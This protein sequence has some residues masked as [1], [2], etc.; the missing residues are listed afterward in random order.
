MK[1]L[2]AILALSWLVVTTA[3]AQTKGKGGVQFKQIPVAAALDAARKAKKPLFVEIYSPTCHVCQG[4]VPTFAESRV[5]RYYNEKFVSAK[6]DVASKEVVN[7]LRKK[8]IFVPSLPLFLY[9]SPQ[10]ELIHMA[11]SNNSADEVIRHGQ[12]AMSPKGRAVAYQQRYESGDRS[13]NFLIDY[14]M[15]ARVTSDTVTNFRLMNDYARQ[16]PANTYANETNWLVLQKLMLD[17]DNP[18]AQYF[19]THLDQYKKYG[20]DRAKEVA[21]NIILSSLYSSRG[22]QFPVAKIIKIREQLIQIGNTPQLASNRTLLMEVN[23][24]FHA[25]DAAKAAQRMDTHAA[26]YNFS[27]PEYLYIVRLFNAKSPDASDGPTVVRWINKVLPQAQNSKDQADLYFELAEVYRRGGKK[28]EGLKA[29]QKSLEL[30]KAANLD[31]KRN[32]DQVAKLR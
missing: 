29:A 22:N 26:Q 24:H 7:F 23:A 8:K 18:L 14:A 32:A 10:G 25:G 15:F 31:T 3:F 11:I 5:G 13:T 28:G 9:F 17:V 2:L 30:A 12:N 19:I 27:V 6:F 21:E 1:K 4:F 16:V 20:A